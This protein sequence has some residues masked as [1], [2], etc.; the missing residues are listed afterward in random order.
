MTLENKRVKYFVLLIVCLLFMVFGASLM[1]LVMLKPFMTITGY[2]RETISTAIE[3]FENYFSTKPYSTTQTWAEF[4]EEFFGADPV[5]F[6]NIKTFFC[7]LQ[8]LSYVPL[9]VL[10]IFFLRKEFA[11]DFVNF[12]KDIKKNLFLVLIGIV[13]MYITVYIVNIVYVIIGVTGESNNESTINLLL[14]SPGVALMVVAVV[15]LAPITE[16]VIFRKL[17]FGTCEETCKFPPAVA[18]I[19]SG[20]VFSFIHVSDLESLKYIF[21]YLALAIPICAIYHY[22]KNNIFVTIIMHIINNL[23]SVLVTLFMI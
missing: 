16:E 18:I 11:E 1:V 20:L 3:A 13:A 17:L 21:Q 8:F 15:I 4:A 2:S 9:L 6:A 19:V 14:D 5:L 23:I 12:K 7:T 10:I 22:S